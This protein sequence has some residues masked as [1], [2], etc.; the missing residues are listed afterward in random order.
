MFSG[1]GLNCDGFLRTLYCDVNNLAGKLYPIA[2]GL[3]HKLCVVQ[4]STIFA[5][6]MFTFENLNMISVSYDGASILSMLLGCGRILYICQE[7][8]CFFIINFFLY[9]TVFRHYIF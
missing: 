8:W 4:G 5:S 9:I 3:C 7:V 1:P 2:I 6:V